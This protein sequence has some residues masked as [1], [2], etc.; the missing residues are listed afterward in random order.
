MD[1][2]W[3]L[4]KMEKMKGKYNYCLKTIFL[5]NKVSRQGFYRYTSSHVL[6]KTAYLYL[7]LILEMLLYFLYFNNIIHNLLLFLDDCLEFLR[8]LFFDFYEN[9]Y[10]KRCTYVFLM[11][12]VPIWAEQ[13]YQYFMT[14]DPVMMAQ[15]APASF[16][17]LYVSVHSCVFLVRTEFL[18]LLL[19]ISII[20][21][22]RSKINV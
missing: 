18:Y 9:K 8:V 15:Y 6:K 22:L 4:E 1:E 14:S 11:F 16:V 10:A 12:H 19:I 13:Y 5:V 21:V 7:L 3:D 17:F 20:F 2:Q